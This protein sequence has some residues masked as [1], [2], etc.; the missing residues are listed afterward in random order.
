MEAVLLNQS[1]RTKVKVE[2]VQKELEEA[3]DELEGTQD[4]LNCVVLSENNKM[5]E[6]DKLKEQLR[7]ARQTID[8]LQSRSDGAGAN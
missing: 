6:I 1:K 8:E 7:A 4:T 3:K 2:K 5:T